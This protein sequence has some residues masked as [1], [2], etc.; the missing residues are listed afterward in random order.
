MSRGKLALKGAV[1]GFAALALAVSVGAGVASAD[2][3]KVEIC[4]NGNTISV[5][6]KAAM[7]HLEKHE[8]DYEGPCETEEA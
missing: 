2:H 3:H 5:P 1:G 8:G 4:H 7:K 6:E